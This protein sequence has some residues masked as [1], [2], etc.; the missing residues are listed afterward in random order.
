MPPLASETRRFSVFL[1]LIYEK[2]EKLRHIYKKI[3]KYYCNSGKNIV[4]Y[5]EGV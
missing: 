1:H 2:I 5:N 3:S 4:K